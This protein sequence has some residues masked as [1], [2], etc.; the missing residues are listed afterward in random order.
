MSRFCR[1][2]QEKIPG[3]LNVQKMHFKHPDEKKFFKKFW[4]ALKKLQTSRH[5]KNRKNFFGPKKNFCTKMHFLAILGPKNVFWDMLGKKFFLVQ[6]K[7][8]FRKFR[9]FPC[10]NP[11]LFGRA[12]YLFGFRGW[13][14]HTN[15]KDGLK[16]I[17]CTI[18]HPPFHCN[19]SGRKNPSWHKVMTGL[20]PDVK[21]KK[22]PKNRVKGDYKGENPKK[23]RFFRLFLF[24]SPNCQNRKFL[25]Q[26]FEFS[27][28]GTPSFKIWSDRP[29][30]FMRKKKL[31]PDYQGAWTPPP[32]HPII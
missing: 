26:T 28:M 17:F 13:G 30:R 5:Q 22:Y 31:W 1:M 12:P 3:V 8:F 32:Y 19:W 15:C 27:L 24:G 20:R 25:V 18:R 9:F 16:C 6:K 23:V 29:N 14:P 2:T 11:Y 4:P 21:S 10:K 7:I